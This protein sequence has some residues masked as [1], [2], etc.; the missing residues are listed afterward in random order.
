MVTIAFFALI[1]TPAGAQNANDAD[2]SA[3]SPAGSMYF[4]PAESARRD[5]APRGR[6][7]SGARRASKPGAAGSPSGGGETSAGAGG[8]QSSPIRSENKYGA[9]SRVPGVEGQRLA[10]LGLADAPAAAPAAAPD[11][12]DDQVPGSFQT[13]GSGSPTQT[14]LLLLLA[15]LIPA[16][17]VLAGRR[18]N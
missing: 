7:F 14:G 2:P 16:G 11:T 9:S 3:G 13:D 12:G 4:I 10:E 6:G 1:S 8:A 15:A 17:L 5:A 18:R